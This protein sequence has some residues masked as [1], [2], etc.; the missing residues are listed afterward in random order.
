MD[1]ALAGGGRGLTK[2]ACTFLRPYSR[3]I[4]LV[5]V[6][7][8][9]QGAGNLFLPLLD[10]VIIDQ[11]VV[12]GDVGY[13]W[14]IGGV[15]LGIA[16]VLGIVSVITTYHASRVSMGVGADLR[17][18]VYRQVRAF[19][20]REIHRFGIASLITRNVNDANQ[21][22]AF[23]QMSL[24]QLIIAAFISVGSLVLAV[25]ESPALSLT[26]LVTIPVMGLIIGVTLAMTLPVSRAMQ[27]KVDR[28]NQVMREQISGVRV[29]RAFLRT[30]AEQDRFHEANV[31]L[32]RSGLRLTRVLAVST[33][34]LVGLLNLCSVGVVWLA[35]RL[36]SEDSLAIGDMS[37]FLVYLLQVLLYV[38]IAVG[39]LL[40]APRAVASAERIARVLETVPAI[41][42]PPRP[43][44]PA[45]V[46]GD[47]EFRHVTFGYPGSERSVLNGLTFCLRPGQTSAIIG[48]TGSGKTTLLNLI[49][50]FLDVT[51]GAVLVNGA[52]VREQSAA[53]LRSGIGLVPQARFLLSGT[54]AS[55]LRF[56]CPQATDAQLWHAL[57][58]A[59]ALDFVASMPGQLDA[60]VDQGGTNVSGGQ[61]QRLCIA[62]ALL[63][64]SPLYLFDDCFSALDAAT[65][66]RLR[67]A[68]H[69]E[70]PDAAVVIVAQRASTVMQADQIIVLDGGEIAGIGTHSQLLAGCGP[71]REIVASNSEKERLHEQGGHAGFRPGDPV[72]APHLVQTRA[73]PAG[74]GDRAQRDLGRPAHR[75]ASDPR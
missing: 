36:I 69:A 10:A 15:M 28:V 64:R 68:L 50:R 13:I 47:V 56:G 58:V 54:V 11:G 1:D 32:T 12:T 30:G 60:P 75:R 22:A 61:R 43:A 51:G 9:I 44:A 20:S 57:E 14:R 17:A 24:T 35:G 73:A 71:Y 33:P 38:L 55:N 72:T 18:A 2:L 49:L 5:V 26:M 37:A 46:T 27:V 70:V 31:D 67:V 8:V 4:G 48:G 65:D 63:R 16:F 42:D 52:D 39:V 3:R 23:L 7:L 40:A 62:R 34:V 25:V 66:A 41:A 45:R 19:S 6:L 59:Q 29:V 21:I 53:Q 74:G